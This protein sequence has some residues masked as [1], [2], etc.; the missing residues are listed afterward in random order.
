MYVFILQVTE[1]IIYNLVY[2]YSMF[3]VFN[4]YIIFVNKLF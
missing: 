4:I 2:Y 1:N 3:A